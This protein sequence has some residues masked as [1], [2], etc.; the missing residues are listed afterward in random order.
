MSDETWVATKYQC[1][2]C[3]SYLLYC[4]AEDGYKCP[5]CGIIQF[6]TPLARFEDST[7]A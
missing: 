3:G 7:D 4:Q 1:F 6:G 5:H 2:V